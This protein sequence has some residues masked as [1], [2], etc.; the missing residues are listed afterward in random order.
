M[1]GHL[2]DVVQGTAPAALVVALLLTA[3]RQEQGEGDA[4]LTTAIRRG[5]LVGVAAAI[6]LSVL[7]QTT[8]LVSREIVALVV[9]V[10][11]LLLEIVLLLW[12]WRPAGAAG[13]SRPA[14][15][16][17]AA[18]LLLVLTGLLLFR[19]LPTVLLQ[20]EGFVA[21]GEPA[22][23]TD[24]LLNVLGYVLG[25]ALVLLTCWAVCRGSASRSA[26]QVR[27]ALTIALAVTVL[28][29]GVAVARILLA[30]DLVD[31][32]RW[33]FRTVVWVLNHDVWLVCALLA[34]GLALPVLSWLADRRR[35]A[36]LADPAS[37][38][39]PA[40]HRL[41]RAAALSRRRFCALAVTGSVLAVL[42]MTAGRAHD[43][44][45]PELSPPEPFELEGDHAVV[46]LAR[47]DDGHLHRFAYRAADGTEVRFIVIRKNDVSYGVALDACDVC[48]STGY[49]ED[50]GKVICK[51]CDVVMNI[52]T[53]GFR[54][55]CNPIPLEHTVADG[56][57]LVAVR[58]LEEA[59]G[60]FA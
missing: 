49:Y 58:D 7:R 21:P 34:A 10:P 59:A 16:R 31:L 5:V 33:V 42:A 50:R 11:L 35:R 25:L 14:P 30:R 24:V 20:T 40:E 27:L 41:A 38:G 53:I 51:L 28:R 9:L 37:F 12:L 47:V 22:L 44:R 26:H 36:V 45:L 56:R 15:P 32:P 60:V 39:N 52:N 18:A 6:V 8:V 19:D 29:Q 3:T 17:V 43:E 13:P 23:S 57:I 54:G 55:G 4:R 46:Q 48:G 2:I 1:L